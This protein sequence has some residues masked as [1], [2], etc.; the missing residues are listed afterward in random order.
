[1]TSRR[2]SASRQRT[3]GTA[4]TRR[5]ASSRTDGSGTQP[6]KR[7]VE[8]VDANILLRDPGEHEFTQRGV[9]ACQHDPLLCRE[10]TLPVRDDQRRQGK[11]GDKEEERTHRQTAAV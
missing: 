8:I 4:A 3:P 10:E 9:D 5:R 6:R 1:M 7:D 2:L 11:D